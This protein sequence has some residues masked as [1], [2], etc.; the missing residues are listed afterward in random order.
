MANNKGYDNTNSGAL[1]KNKNKKEMAD[2]KDTSNW[3]E[4]Q[5]KLN[6]D[7]KDFFISAWIKKPKK[8]GDTFMSLS[9]QPAN[10]SGGKGG[11]S[12]KEEPENFDDDEL[13]F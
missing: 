7:G 11:G 9:I 1:F 3:P 10:N 6:V 8:G 13:P 12:K 5:G 2:T 4:Y